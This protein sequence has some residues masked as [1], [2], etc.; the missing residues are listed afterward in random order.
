MVWETALI[1]EH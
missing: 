1:S